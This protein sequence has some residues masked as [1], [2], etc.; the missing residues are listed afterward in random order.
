MSW[1]HGDDLA[2]RCQRRVPMRVNQAGDHHAP[3]AVDHLHILGALAGG[4]Q[5][6]DAPAIDQ[7]AHAF[8]RRQGF[9]VEHPQVGQQLRPRRGLGVQLVRR[10]AELRERAS[11]AAIP[12]IVCRQE[13]SAS[14]RRMTARVSGLLQWQECSFPETGCG[15]NQA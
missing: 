15:G 3:A 1:V 2:D 9:A 13:M 4:E 5:G 12:P 14:I 8:A 6:G 11:T 7:D 10:Q